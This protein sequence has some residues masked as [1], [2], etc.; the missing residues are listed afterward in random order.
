MRADDDEQVIASASG[1]IVL[2]QAEALAHEPL[3]P[4]PPRRG[5]D[6]T[7]NAE[8]ESRMSEVVRLCVHDQRPARLANFGI[9]DGREVGA[10]A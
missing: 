10:R 9:I 2:E 3:D 6:L 1:E 5:A 8:A 4:V 7:R